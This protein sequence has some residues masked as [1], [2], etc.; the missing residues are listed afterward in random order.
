MMRKAVLTALLLGAWSALSA[1]EI[2]IEQNKDPLA[3]GNVGAQDPTQSQVRIELR[4][5]ETLE[6]D[7]IGYGSRVYQVRIKGELR[8]IPERDVLSV[9]FVA[10]EKS[11]AKDKAGKAKAE[12]FPL[13]SKREVEELL[14]TMMM[15]FDFEDLSLADILTFVG[16]YTRQNFHVTSAARRKL[17]TTKLTLAL[18]GQPIWTCLQVVL[19][20]TRLDFACRED[21]IVV[22]KTTAEQGVEWKSEVFEGM[23]TE[24]FQQL[25]RLATSVNFVDTR[26]G[27]AI[28]FLREYTGVQMVIS[29]KASRL[30]A[31]TTVSAT[32]KE[33]TP[34]ALLELIL[35]DA[36]LVAICRPDGFLV[37]QPG[38]QEATATAKEYRFFRVQNIELDTA[39][40]DGLKQF[41]GPDDKVDYFLP[42]RAFYVEAPKETLE[43]IEH[44]LATVDIAR[45][46]TGDDED[47]L[48]LPQQFT[49]DRLRF[50]KL[51]E[52]CRLQVL[53]E[54]QMRL[55]FKE[56]PIIAKTAQEIESLQEAGELSV[57]QDLAAH[58]EELYGAW[59]WADDDLFLF[60]A[61]VN[62]AEA[63]AK[64][65]EASETGRS[66]KLKV[67][68]F[69]SFPYLIGLRY[70]S[71]TRPVVV[72]WFRGE[73]VL[74]L[75][76]DRKLR[77]HPL[78]FYLEAPEKVRNAAMPDRAPTG[79]RWLQGP[80][81]AGTVDEKQ[82][83]VTLPQE[84]E[85][86]LVEATPRL[87]GAYLAKAE[88]ADGMYGPELRLQLKAEEA[89]LMKA[90]SSRAVGRK[91]AVVFKGKMISSPTNRAEVGQS[92]VIQ[93]AFSRAELEKILRDIRSR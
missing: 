59:Y 81:I 10:P 14:R 89:A 63:L 28:D 80:P 47:S 13:R 3:I 23:E 73:I 21:G 29:P 26:F 78:E 54:E 6:G 61:K 38:K 11:P 79:Y 88:I 66:A 76:S 70:K 5:G 32:L 49:L 20:D 36:N 85:Q 35:H 27:D 52:G 33:I 67:D 41:V 1:Q 77:P 92:V 50:A 42:E 93:G 74:R 84:G 57:P 62:T 24:L 48:G 18:K 4:S 15:D 53:T 56:N 68:Y 83:I 22:I 25:S 7:L 40:Q 75:Y 30:T 19:L 82:G 17:E 31:K 2:D 51:P 45:G 16:D 86:I 44:Y 39:F 43:K 34:A 55:G 65:R 91:L 12:R 71:S 9:S 58:I 69:E 64:L 60:A 90:M 87:T 46:V 72:H 8:E 37:I